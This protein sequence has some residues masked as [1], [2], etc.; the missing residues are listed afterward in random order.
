MTVDYT[1][2]ISGDAEVTE[3]TYR[4]DDG[5]QTVTNLTSTWSQTVDVSA[6]TSVEITANAEVRSGSVEVGYVARDSDDNVALEES[7]G[8]DVNSD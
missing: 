5:E 2:A 7:D 3:L 6:G 4:T 8:C 1:A